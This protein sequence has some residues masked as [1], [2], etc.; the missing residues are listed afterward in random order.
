[1]VTHA[2]HSIEKAQHLSLMNP[3]QCWSEGQEQMLLLLKFIL[4]LATPASAESDPSTP[5]QRMCRGPLP[6]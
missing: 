4:R 2:S 5:T 3:P 1:M 6:E